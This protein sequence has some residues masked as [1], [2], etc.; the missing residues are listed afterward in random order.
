MLDPPASMTSPSPCCA[1]TAPPPLAKLYSQSGGGARANELLTLSSHTRIL[2]SRVPKLLNMV[3]LIVYF[4]YTT[5]PPYSVGPSDHLV[6]GRRVPLWP[7]HG[8]PC[9][10]VAFS[11]LRKKDACFK[12]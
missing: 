9:A 7:F 1:T 12:I 10:L 2:V 5:K 6:W 8:S 3:A 11:R 4:K